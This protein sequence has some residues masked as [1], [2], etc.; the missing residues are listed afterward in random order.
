MSAG[1]ARRQEAVRSRIARLARHLDLG[2]LL[3]VA[4]GP[5]WVASTALV[6]WRFVV[7][8]A[9]PVAAA[10]AAVGAVVAALVR[11]RRRAFTEAQAAVVA[12]GRAGLGGLL[13]TRLE[14]PVGEWELELN[15][16]LKALT[17]PA[18]QWRRPA[19][20][21]GAALGFV[22]LGLLVPRATRVAAPNAAAA[23]RVE[24]LAE[25]HAALFAEETPEDSRQADQEL[26]RLRAELTQG[27]FD[28]PDWEAAD[29]LDGALERRAAEVVAELAR[30]EAAAG[31]LGEVLAAGGGAEAAAR[32]RRELEEALLGLSSTEATSGAAAL[33]EA[34]A[35]H[36]ADAGSAGR[37]GEASPAEV[38]Q[39]RQALA[40]RRRQLEAGLGEPRPGSPRGTSAARSGRAAP[41]GSRAGRS[42]A[43]PAA[44][45]H[46]SRG[47][48]QGG[49]PGR[50]G[51]AGRLVFGAEAEMDPARLK[52]ELTPPGHGGEGGELFGL[53]ARD[54]ALA[55]GVVAAAP[56]QGA[57]PTGERGAGHDPGAL[58]PRHRALV[59]RYF[60]TEESSSSSSS[61]SRRHRVRAAE[62]AGSA[63]RR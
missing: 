34:L 24:A 20:L 7:G 50:G 31:R 54:P 23:S 1:E 4:V 62:P 32:E 51:E 21:L 47:V 26:E 45:G 29:A 18:L 52:L 22:G 2:V 5:A 53:A 56:A 55:S 9:L 60:D 38:E 48:E 19:A 58:S 28:G 63:E 17:L 35:G 33:T 40:E 13:L 11:L 25:K 12:D 57:A 39:L 27:T 61:S 49:G 43:A 37:A 6:A 36:G 46:A 44:G 3:E 10:F 30:A 8:G 15:Q 42:G 14:R 41:S 59:R 16:K